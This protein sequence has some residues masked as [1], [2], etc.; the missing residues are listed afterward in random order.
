M[1][2]TEAAKEPYGDVPYAD[3]G[4]QADGKKRY[5]IDSEAHC[6]SAWSY[7]NQAE[8]AAQ[9]SAEDLKKVKARIAAAA[10][11]Y[12]IEISAKEALIDKEGA[13]ALD[14]A[15]EIE[16]PEPEQ[17][18]EFSEELHP[19]AAAGTATCGQFCAGSGRASGS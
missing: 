17:T 3:P 4:Y 15:G 19:R 14:S 8:N 16:V 6:R 13:V 2:V 9:Y 7:I 5:P 12:G 11:K 1:T 10:K 18:R